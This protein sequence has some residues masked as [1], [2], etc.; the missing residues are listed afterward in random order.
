VEI[1]GEIKMKKQKILAFLP[2]YLFTFLFLV[3]N[4]NVIAQEH[5][6]HPNKKLGKSEHPEHPKDAKFTSS[7]TC[8]VQ[9]LS[10]V[11]HKYVDREYKKN[12]GY[13]LVKDE[14]QNKTLELKLVKVHEEKLSTLGN[15][16]YFVCADFEG[17]DGN[18]YDVDIFMKGRTKDDLVA[19][20][21][22]IHKQNSKPRYSWFEENGVWKKKVN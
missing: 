21:T 3:I 1:K 8:T 16:I 22:N 14:K 13:F 18:I 9:D 12:N 10:E 2:I 11:A 5:P 4:G 20:E 6:E 17:K 7:A 19:I 15:D